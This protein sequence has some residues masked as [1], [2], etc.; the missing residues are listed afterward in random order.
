MNKRRREETADVVKRLEAIKN[1]IESLMEEEQEYLDSMP[2]SLQG[3]E[4][5]G[6]ATEAVDNYQ[7]ALDEFE[8]ITSYLEDAS[9]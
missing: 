3:S 5:G 7:Y 1:E 2:E 6:A 4:K 8:S 9:A